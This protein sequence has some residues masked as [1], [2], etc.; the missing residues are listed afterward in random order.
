MPLPI[1]RP[2]LAGAALLI[3]PKIRPPVLLR[4]RSPAAPAAHCRAHRRRTQRLLASRRHACVLGAPRRRATSAYESRGQNRSSSMAAMAISANP[5]RHAGAPAVT[6]AKRVDAGEQV[7][8][9][10]RRRTNAVDQPDRDRSAANASSTGRS[11]AS[12]S[13]TPGSMRRP[14]FARRRPRRV[15]G[16]PWSRLCRLQLSRGTASA[17]SFHVEIALR[18]NPG[19]ERRQVTQADRGHGVIQFHHDQAALGPGVERALLQP[20]PRRREDRILRK[21]QHQHVAGRSTGR[22]RGLAVIEF[23]RTAPGARGIFRAPR[24][25][26]WSA[27][28]WAT[29]TVMGPS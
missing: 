22:H 3:E 14:R 13:S 27:G 25:P 7:A 28:A 12:Q 9:T 15:S 8:P 1:F 4:L 6:R 11:V 29:K 26:C 16:S 21:Q 23:A 19:V 2:N 5:R 18:F 10:A 24:R 17:R 20:Q